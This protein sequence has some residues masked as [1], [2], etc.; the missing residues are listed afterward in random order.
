MPRKPKFRTRTQNNPQPGKIAER[1]EWLSRWKVQGV[2]MLPAWAP[3][4]ARANLRKEVEK[5]LVRYGPEDPFYEIFDIVAALA[6]EE[7]E[8]QRQKKKTFLDDWALPT[9]A[10]AAAATK[11]PLVQKALTKGICA[12]H[13]RVNHWFNKDSPKKPTNDESKGK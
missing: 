2:L 12:F 13:D 8:Q 11:T 9:I 5:A 6:Q 10:L 3:A 4:A 7:S 1:K